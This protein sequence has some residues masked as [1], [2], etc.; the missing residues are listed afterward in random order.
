MKSIF[1]IWLLTA[2]VGLGAGFDQ[3]QAWTVSGNNI[4]RYSGSVYIPQ[5]GIGASGNNSTADFAF[6]VTP[7]II[8]GSDSNNLVFQ[9]DAYSG[10]NVWSCRRANGV[11]SSPSALKSGD[12]IL[13]IGGRGYGATGYAVGA[14]ASITFSAEQD[15][16]DTAHGAN[17]QF[18]T[19]TNNSAS[20]TVHAAIWGSGNFGNTADM[21]AGTL[22]PNQ[23]GYASPIRVFTVLGAAGTTSR[24]VMELVAASGNVAAGNSIG[25]IDF[26][27]LSQS[28]I[29]VAQIYATLSGSTVGNLGGDLVFAVKGDNSTAT[30]R[31]TLPQDGGIKIPIISVVPGTPA[32]GSVTLFACTNGSAK[33]VCVAKFS[34]GSTNVF[35]T[36]P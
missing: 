17:I 32:A 33:V 31:L 13:G 7:F 8:T 29:R 28:A 19:T 14:N 36:Q 30:A 18:S 20:Q 6:P 24:A 22:Y 9:M 1:T 4:Y 2:V 10:H 34:D 5:I 11:F 15:W 16:T 23:F 21:G 35:A 3:P 27:A 12:E 26:S 25:Q